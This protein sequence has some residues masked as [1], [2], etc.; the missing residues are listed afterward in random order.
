[1]TAMGVY[2]LGNTDPVEGSL[3]RLGT[4]RVDILFLHRSDS[5]VEPQEVARAFDE[6]WSAGKARHFG[7]SNHT[8]TQI[9]LLRKFVTRPLVVN[10]VQLGL[11]HPYLIVD[12]IEADREGDARIT[13]QY[14]GAAG[15]LDYRRL[16]DIQVQAWSPLNCAADQVSMSRE[17]CYAL[18]AAG[19]GVSSR[20]FI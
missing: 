18:L 3:K 5:L 2:A 13:R 8:A 20:T 15:T 14:T 12:G 11:M 17:E 16:H 19:T 9:E 10:Q 4:D 1:M 6:L 7:V